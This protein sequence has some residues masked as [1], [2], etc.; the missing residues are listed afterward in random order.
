MLLD[1]LFLAF[2]IDK[3]PFQR[4]YDQKRW[5][6]STKQN[7][8]IALLQQANSKQAKWNWAFVFF[9]SWHQ[10]EHAKCF[11]QTR[12]QW[13]RLMPMIHSYMILHSANSFMQRASSPLNIF[14]I[15]ILVTSGKKLIKS[16]FYIEQ[17]ICR[18]ER[19]LYQLEI[20]MRQ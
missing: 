8:S 12:C 10:K 20:N 13:F 14:I 7:Y 1:M 16:C 18:R 4:F 3:V 17:V 2:I 11:R 5:H 19:Q 15:L 9:S 6:Q